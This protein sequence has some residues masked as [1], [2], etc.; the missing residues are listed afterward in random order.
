MRVWLGLT[1]LFGLPEGHHPDDLMQA[2]LGPVLRAACQDIV[3]APLPGPIARL[4]QELAQ[5]E[6]PIP[7][8]ERPRGLT[9][10][11]VSRPTGR[12][13]RLRRVTA[14]P[15]LGTVAAARGDTG[16]LQLRE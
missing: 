4:T 3:D 14:L 2:A 10:I 11:G 6:R 5:R 13:V 8:L 12:P 1:H 7:P 9:P 16:K 15:R